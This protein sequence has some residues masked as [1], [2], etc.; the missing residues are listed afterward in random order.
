MVFASWSTIKMKSIVLTTLSIFL[1]LFFLLIGTLKVSP[2]VNR[3]MHREIRRNYVRYAKVF[4]LPNITGFRVSPKYYRLI[5]GWSEIIAGLTLAIIPGR[6]KQLANW[7]LLILTILGLYTHVVV[8]DKFEKTAPSIVFMLM[9]TCRLIVHV[10]VRR[11]EAAKPK[12][13]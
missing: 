6:I 1:G 7:I 4:P 13:D 9:L 8:K 10:Q 3:D 2:S 12:T 11:R 5:V